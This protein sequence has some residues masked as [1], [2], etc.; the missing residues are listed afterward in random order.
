M[1]ETQCLC[2]DIRLHITEEPLA[3]VYCHCTDC[4]VSQG[5]A[6]VI[7]SVYRADAVKVV[8]GNPATLTVQR[9]PRMRCSRCGTPLFTEVAAAGLRSLNAYLLP[10]DKVW[11][12]LH[13]HCADA[14]M[15]VVDSL[16]HYAGLPS[17][18]GGDDKLVEW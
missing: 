13:I 18:F 9:T 6:Y 3:Q 2:G 12:Q 16:P 5:A 1:I 10:P 17:S 4:Q 14:V 11:P 8:S 15:P 7:N